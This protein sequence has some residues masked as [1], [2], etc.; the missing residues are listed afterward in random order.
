MSILEVKLAFQIFWDGLIRIAMYT[1]V[2][3][4]LEQTYNCRPTT[5]TAVAFPTHFQ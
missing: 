5:A 1:V 3:Y 4:K 2:L